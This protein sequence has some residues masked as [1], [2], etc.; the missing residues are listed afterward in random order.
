M[1]FMVFR[2]RSKRKLSR[3][4]LQSWTQLSRLVLT[5]PASR[6]CLHGGPACRL[7]TEH[8]IAVVMEG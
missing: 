2:G 7:E 3:A 1:S 4:D 5:V 8:R 6:E